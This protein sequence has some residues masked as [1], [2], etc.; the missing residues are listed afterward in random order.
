MSSSDQVVSW[1]EGVPTPLIERRHLTEPRSEITRMESTRPRVRRVETE[2]LELMEVVW[3]M[4]EDQYDTFRTFFI[5]D[6]DQGALMFE[7][8][9][10]EPAPLAGYIYTVT[11]TLAFLD[12]N[13]THSISDN[14]VTVNAVLEVDSEEYEETEDAGQDIPFPEEPEIGYT[15]EACR[16]EITIDFETFDGHINTAID[17][18]PSATGPWTF[19]CETRA[20]ISSLVIG[21]YFA[22]RWIRVKAQSETGQRVHIFQP[23]APAVL[24]PDFTATVLLGGDEEDTAELEL[25]TDLEPPR[26]L[27]FWTFSAVKPGREIAAINEDLKID[28]ATGALCYA[29]TVGSTFVEVGPR[30]VHNFKPDGNDNG[31]IVRVT[32]QSEQEGV[33]IRATTDGTDPTLSNGSES[34]DFDPFQN[35]GDHSYVIVRAF[36]GECRSPALYIPIDIRRDINTSITGNIQA[37]SG[38]KTQWCGRFQW[39]EVSEGDCGPAPIE[40]GSQPGALPWDG[41]VPC[42]V[43]PEDFL[44]EALALSCASGIL[45]E[46]TWSGGKLQLQDL[47]FLEEFHFETSQH[48][49]GPNPGTCPSGPF[50]GGQWRIHLETVHTLSFNFNWNT[51]GWCSAAPIADDIFL[52]SAEVEHEVNEIMEEIILPDQA[53]EARPL[54]EALTGASGGGTNNLVEKLTDLMAVESPDLLECG[55]TSNLLAV[56]VTQTCCNN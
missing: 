19:W 53:E 2:G 37:G 36:I 17:F 49:D 29:I 42:F 20:Q 6:L 21:N 35:P 9:T 8:V 4:T 23:E 16:D 51:Q 41:S 50:G 46:E 31:D 56:T 7:M 48:Y 1:P 12:G 39:E 34:V 33:T 22:G 40:T 26:T 3:N 15:N 55:G 32:F 45:N 10:F 52:L 54:V 28:P 5:E 38:Q 24:P 18:G 43:D 11:R 47:T 13:Y 27:I 44:Q 14:L 30:Y 25:S